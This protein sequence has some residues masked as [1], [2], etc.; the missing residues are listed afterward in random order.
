M[1]ALIEEWRFL[2]IYRV[3]SY[4]CQ[5]GNLE[6]IG[7]TDRKGFWVAYLIYFFAV[8]YSPIKYRSYRRNMMKLYKSKHV[9]NKEQPCQKSR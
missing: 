1:V 6:K 3:H 5:V 9:C 7:T 4:V 8:E 2:F